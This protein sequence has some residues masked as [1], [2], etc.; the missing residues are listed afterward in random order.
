[1]SATQL[2]WVG[3]CRAH[4][5]PLAK[6]GAQPEHGLSRAS[7]HKLLYYLATIPLIQYPGMPWVVSKDPPLLLPLL[8]V[9]KI[10]ES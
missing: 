4:E 5:I 10:Q 8:Y 9:Q 3:K 1:M 6:R 2:P 7:K